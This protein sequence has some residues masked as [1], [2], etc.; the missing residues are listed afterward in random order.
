M[1]T[2]NNNILVTIE[3]SVHASR[4]T[5]FFLTDRIKKKKKPKKKERE[6]PSY[7]REASYLQKKEKKKRKKP[8]IQP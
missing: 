7:L 5:S 6:S 2:K 8:K 4:S 3:K 1:H